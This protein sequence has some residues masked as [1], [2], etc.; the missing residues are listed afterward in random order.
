[1]EGLARRWPGKGPWDEV[2]FLEIEAG[3]QQS[4]WLRYTLGDGEH[5]RG[6]STWAIATDGEQILADQGHHRL[7]AL[8]PVAGLSLG[9]DI[10]LT[11]T[12][13]RGMA[14]DARWDLALHVGARRHRMVPAAIERLGIGR[15]YVPA[16]LDL[17]VTGEAT[18]GG[19]TFKLER[20]PAVLGHIWGAKN[21][22]RQWAWCHARFP[23]HDVLLEGLSVGL[24]PLPL[25][26][27]LG[28]WVGQTH[29]D[30]S[31]ALQLARTMSQIDGDR[32]TFRATQR[33][34]TVEGVAE[35][36]PSSQVATVRYLDPRDGGVRTCRNSGRSRLSLTVIAPDRTLHLDTTHA[37]FEV[38][39]IG[40]PQGAI[41]L[42]D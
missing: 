41:I 27:T 38:A 34:L 16:G 7:G 2:W 10:E 9:D 33:G 32:W 13:A 20:A 25:L 8:R 40:E 18:V 37:A 30:L 19:R 31:S 26:T 35:L 17:H 39:A 36:P 12:V 15:T 29:I 3:P 22:T 14:G 28:V 6:L 42:S 1:M 5:R 23:E 4:L 21:R 11:T 24:G